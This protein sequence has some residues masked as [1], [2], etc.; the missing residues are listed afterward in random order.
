MACSA[1]ALEFAHRRLASL[2]VLSGLEAAEIYDRTLERVRHAVLLVHSFVSRD[3]ALDLM[4]FLDLLTSL[5]VGS[6]EPVGTGT[7]AQQGSSL[8]NA[9]PGMDA[10]VSVILA[11]KVQIA[12]ILPTFDCPENHAVATL[13][14][15]LK[16]LGEDRVFLSAAGY[17][18]CLA[19]VQSAWQRLL[20]VGVQRWQLELLVSG[21][22][23]GELLMPQWRADQPPVRK[24]RRASL[25]DALTAG[26]PSERAKALEE[27]D[28]EVLAKTTIGPYESRI[29]TWRQ[30]CAKWELPAFPL[31]ER[32][33]RAVGASLK[34][35]RY[36]SSEQY[37]SA[38]ASHQV[39]RMHTVV[40]G[41]IKAMIRDCVRSVRRGLG[42]SSLKDSFDL[43]SLA[44]AVVEGSEFRA[45]SWSDLPAA[46]DA[47]IVASYFC[48]R[49][50]EMASAS[51]SHL[52]FQNNQLQILLPAHKT[53]SQGE[54]TSRA[55]FCGCA[56]R[57][58][59]LCPYHAGARH[60]QRLEIL[61][62]MLDCKALP[63]FPQDDGT[64]LSKADMIMTIR[65][66]LKRAGV[67]TTRPD[68]AGIQVERFGGHVLRVAG[69]QHLFLLGLRFDM[70]QLH[71]RWSS[72]AVQKYL[73]EAPLL[74]VP[75][76]VS[77]ALSS[78]EVAHRP[79]E[80][81]QGLLA[82][83][84][85]QPVIAA[86]SDGSAAQPVAESC[87][88][89]RRAAEIEAM[90]LQFSDFTSRTQDAAE[91]LVVNTR[92]SAAR[93]EWPRCKRCFPR[94]KGDFQAAV[95]VAE[96]VNSALGD[97]GLPTT[98]P[99][100]LPGIMIVAGD[101][102]LATLRVGGAALDHRWPPEGEFAV[103][104][105]TELRTGQ[106]FMSPQVFGLALS[107]WGSGSSM[108]LQT[109]AD[110]A[111]AGDD[112][113]RYLALRGITSAGTLSMIATGEAEYRD[114]VIAPLLAG[115]GVGADRIALD[116][117]DRPIASAILLYMRKLSIDATSPT[118]SPPTTGAP[119]GTASPGAIGTGTAAKDAD[120]V[121]R[122]LPAGVWTEQIRKYEAVQIHGRNRV[123][124]QQKLLG[125]ESSLAKLWH[126]LKVSGDFT[127]LPLGE[128][129]SRRSF[130]A[131]GAVNSLSKRKISRELV[132]DVDRDRLVAEDA[133]DSWEPRSMLAVIDA[134]EALRWAFI[135]LEYGHEFDINA[136]FD[137]FIH[138]A[139]QRPQQLDGFRSY[140][141]SASWKL[142]REMRAGRTFSEAVTTVREDLHLYQEVMSRPVQTGGKQQTSPGNP[143]KKRKPHEDS[144]RKEDDRRKRQA[145]EGQQQQ[146]QQWAAKQNQDWRKWRKPQA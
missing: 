83:T 12:L 54:L 22:R 3:R 25:A 24:R 45:F 117:A 33:V 146:S 139:R 4:P 134:L 131:T 86:T 19:D 40:P 5:Q 112:I 6:F 38:A 93:P 90:R 69:T 133:E 57:S 91:T 129:M 84:P 82:S 68:E 17:V 59:P 97:L 87:L 145:W 89:D 75:G 48:M 74:L 138:K 56:V 10:E 128:L 63:L 72:L 7:I 42:P 65:E 16:D 110:K 106:H 126:Q 107:L 20:D 95:E 21:S 37:F 98:S 46:I 8:E 132:V 109:I 85:S 105:A 18:F 30:I 88:P 39:R 64:A 78:G 44:S 115:F 52:Y 118:T 96:R 113:R 43:W 70:I 99:L 28:R 61:Q 1:R 67:Q 32:N 49:E 120:K 79:R 81:P 114:V 62:A 111:G 144:P 77:R 102:A 31:D 13:T 55:L 71:G 116:A 15:I 58:Q 143:N 92:T 23:Q 108:D 80:G 60:L 104:R 26:E 94:D 142:C 101:Q 27:L 130:D 50:I 121:P 73:Q 100:H 136:L 127:P 137:D 66:T 141:E 9:G 119:S 122:T 123:F 11:S 76:A 140:Y 135:L 34:R 47:L 29:L 125:A 35:G 51:S 53:S 2:T 41:H 103:Q 36:R 124:P 14:R